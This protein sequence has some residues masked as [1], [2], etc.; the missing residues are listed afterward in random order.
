MKKTVLL[1]TLCLTAML[2]SAQDSARFVTNSGQVLSL[3]KEAKFQAVVDKIDPEAKPRP[4]SA[5]IGTA[6]RNMLKRAGAFQAIL[7][8]VYQHQPTYDIVI[9]HCRFSS[10]KMDI[11]TVYGKNNLLRGVF[12]MPTDERE[13]YSAPSYYQPDKIEEQPFEVINGDIRLKGVLTLP[14]GQSNVPVVILIHGSGPNDKDETVGAT[15]IFRDFSYGFPANG[16][17]VLRFDKRT[18]AMG[19]MLIR[20]NA[21]LTPEEETVSDAVAAIAL[22]KKDVRID[23][24]RIFLLG[25][26]MGAYLLPRIIQ[27]SG[28]VAG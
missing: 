14:K 16:V 1:I 24:T 25:H 2:A 19:A 12:F 15:K 23:S 21:I 13:R 18:R 10:L 4:D 5:R 28:G 27:R 9:F 7:D 20:T 6:W 26:S 11:K 8:T 22:M 3:L 17:A